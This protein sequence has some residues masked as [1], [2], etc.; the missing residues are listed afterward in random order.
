MCRLRYSV[1][2]QLLVLVFYD[3]IKF[4]IIYYNVRFLYKYVEDVKRDVFFKNVNIFVFFEIRLIE[5]DIFVLYEIDGYNL[6]RY[7]EKKDDINDRFYYGFVVY[8]KYFMIF[9]NLVFFGVDI[10]FGN[11][12][13][14][15]RKIILCF[16]Y[17]LLK[18]FVMYI[19]KKVFEKLLKECDYFQIF[20]IIM[21]DFNYSVEILSDFVYKKYLLRQIINERIINYNLLIDYIYINLYFE[22]I[23][24]WGVLEFYYLDYKL[25]YIDL[26]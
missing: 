2:V 21:G 9:K 3:V 15:N 5:I 19:F 25:I 14:K 6:Y 16:L 7:D 24:K 11:L 22:S 4:Q 13:Y 26:L 10:V 20:I 8:Y 17:C 23:F 12:F 18:I 1:N